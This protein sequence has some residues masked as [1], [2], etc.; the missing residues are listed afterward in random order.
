MMRRRHFL[1]IA[2]VA[3]DATG[4]GSDRG[5]PPTFHM[6]VIRGT[7]VDNTNAPASRVQAW[8]S[9]LQDEP[10]DR[11]SPITGTGGATTTDTLGFFRHNVSIVPGSCF[12]I[13]AED[14]GR[15]PFST[16]TQFVDFGV[17][18]NGV[19]PDSIEV[20]LRFP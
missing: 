13:W 9:Q 16:D 12:R 10:C 7:V 19:F 4:T 5:D 20:K 2:L 6:Q 3:C 1:L 17:Q 8:W 14:F 15:R 18:V 11:T